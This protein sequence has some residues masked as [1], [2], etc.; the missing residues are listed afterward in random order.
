MRLLL[1]AILVLASACAAR[2]D[3]A[4]A[5]T[6]WTPAQITDGLR[7]ASSA[8]QAWAAWHAGQTG[9]TAAVPALKALTADRSHLVRRVAIDA[10][11]R[12]RVAPNATDAVQLPP[13]VAAILLSQR[14]PP[15]RDIVIALLRETRTARRSWWWTGGAH[16]HWALNLGE[17][18]KQWAAQV[19]IGLLTEHPDAEAVSAVMAAAATEITLEIGHPEQ[20]GGPGPLL[21]WDY[22]PAWPPIRQWTLTHDRRVV[23]AAAIHWPIPGPADPPVFVIGV[24]RNSA[25]RAGLWIR[26]VGQEPGYAPRRSTAATAMRQLA[27]WAGLPATAAPAAELTITIAADDAP[28]DHAGIATTPPGDYEPD[29]TDPELLA[30]LGRLRARTLAA[31]RSAVR[32]QEVLRQQ[33]LAGLARRGLRVPSA[34]WWITITMLDGRADRRFAPPAQ[35]VIEDAVRDLRRMLAEPGK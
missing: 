16:P 29:P 27:S 1:L 3:P 11:I 17:T 5:P 13:H 34:N 15:D 22:N 25:T 31:V 32:E 10:L 26:D 18:Q 19:A 35:E 4:A 24:D 8:V 7:S 6:A 28:L 2:P 21:S 20:A 14:S 30:W 9:A 12:L 23:S 33:V